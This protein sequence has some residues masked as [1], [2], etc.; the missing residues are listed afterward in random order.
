MRNTHD[1][2]SLLN[3]WDSAVD[4]R[5]DATVDARVFPT[6]RIASETRGLA[7]SG[8]RLQPRVSNRR[9]S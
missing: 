1:T 6:P 2:S 8:V 4:P 3:T 5:I 9:H 7:G